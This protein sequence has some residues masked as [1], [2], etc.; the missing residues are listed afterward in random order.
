MDRGGRRRY[1]TRALVVAALALA[2]VVVTAL[3]AAAATKHVSGFVY[4]GCSGDWNYSSGRARLSE[5]WQGTRRVDNVS[6]VGASAVVDDLINCKTDKPM[7]AYQIRLTVR[8][9]LEAFGIDCTD[10]YPSREVSCKT[11]DSGTRYTTTKTCGTTVA[12]CRRGF[13]ALH[14]YA[15][16]GVFITGF[17]M[18]ST[19]VL[20]RKDGEDFTWATPRIG[21]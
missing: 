8:F 5:Y 19:A 14:F 4:T 21:D 12:Q 15:P 10:S 2:G 16:R 7:T 18:E 1:L 20:I 13:G 3:P 9:N 17:T 11:T 6:V